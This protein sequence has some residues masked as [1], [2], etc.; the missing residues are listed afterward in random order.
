MAMRAQHISATKSS[1]TIPPQTI[2]ST[3]LSS[4]CCCGES[5]DGREKAGILKLYAFDVKKKSDGRLLNENSYL[6]TYLIQEEM[7]GKI[8]HQ[9]MTRIMTDDG[10]HLIRRVTKVLMPNGKYRYPVDYFDASPD[11]V[12]V[13][14]KELDNLR[15]PGYMMLV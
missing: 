1:S 13:S 9:K 14:D 12:K 8:V 3:T 2:T 10:Q 6:C 11:V 7:M 4:P 15:V 5:L